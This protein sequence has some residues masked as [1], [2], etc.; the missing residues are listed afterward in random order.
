MATGKVTMEDV[1]EKSGISKTTVSYILNGKNANFQISEATV[2]KVAE[3]A[4]SLGYHTEKARAALTALESA[5]TSILVV[6]PWLYAQHSD[7]MVQINRALQQEEREHPVEFVYMQY[8][9]GEIGKVLRPMVFARYD[10][11]FAVGSGEKD[12]EYL[13][14]NRENLSKVILINRQI[15]GL[16]SVSGNDREASY[17][18]AKRICW[19]RTYDRFLVVTDPG[20]WCSRF[21]KEGFLQALSEEGQKCQV[22]DL[23]SKE[24]TEEDFRGL[25][26]QLGERGMVFFTQYYAAACFLIRHPEKIPGVGVACYDEDGLISRFL[27]KPLTTMDP[28]ITRM[29]RAAIALAQQLKK[30]EPTAS[31][32]IEAQLV[33][34]ETVNFGNV[35]P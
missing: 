14:R 23:W 17:R 13:E 35:I 11:V 12:L 15:E 28:R 25:E 26:R 21:R 20:S 22:I 10:A 5:R 1:A 2:R 3:A 33:A 34:G 9:E 29:A 4:I 32:I 31:V 18:L 8:R 30:G 16:L 24:A 7:F 19:A 6:S 27:P